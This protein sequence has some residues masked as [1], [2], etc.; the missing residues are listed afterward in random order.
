MP[1]PDAFAEVIR[2]KKKLKILHSNLIAEDQCAEDNKHNADQKDGNTDQSLNGNDD[3][4]KKYPDR[5][6]PKGTYDEPDDQCNK[7]GLIHMISPVLVYAL[8]V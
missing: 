1:V 3:F 6:P 4:W 7:S 8:L 2:M 5:V